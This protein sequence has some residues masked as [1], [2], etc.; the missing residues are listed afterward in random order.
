MII[1]IDLAASDHMGAEAL[2]QLGVG[3]HGTTPEAVQW[4]L[5]RQ[6][7]KVEEGLAQHLDR[8]VKAQRRKGRAGIVDHHAARGPAQLR[9]IAAVDEIDPARKAPLSRQPARDGR[10]I[11]QTRIQGMVLDDQTPI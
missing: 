9:Q 3:G 7:L 8:R 2:E 11:D 5:V 1:A 10:Q 4:L 6:T